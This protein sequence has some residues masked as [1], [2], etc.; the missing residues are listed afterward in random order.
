MGG[1]GLR[2]EDDV[3]VKEKDDMVGEMS[4]TRLTMGAPDGRCRAVATP[5]SRGG[6]QCGRGHRMFWQ[7]VSSKI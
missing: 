7:R 4:T 6:C 5:V 3:P 2:R 1:R